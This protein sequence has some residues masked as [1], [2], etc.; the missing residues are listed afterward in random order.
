[1]Y[2]SHNLVDVG[3][4]GYA[5]DHCWLL[6]T[7]DALQLDVIG[8]LGA[9][10][11]QNAWLWL[12]GLH[13]ADVDDSTALL[14]VLDCTLGN[15]EV[16]QDIGVEGALQSG[17]TYIFKLFYKLV[18]KCCIVDQDVNAAPLLDCLIHNVSA[19]RHL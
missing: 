2:S 3:E 11:V 14:H 7:V 4:A 1:M 17:T 18:L 6:S 9:G 15:G 13:R 10:I 8:Y 19:G 12:V 5:T 16:S